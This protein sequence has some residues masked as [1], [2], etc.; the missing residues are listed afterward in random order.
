MLDNNT[1]LPAFSR[2]HRYNHQYCLSLILT[3]EKK[4]HEEFRHSI[5]EKKAQ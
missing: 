1:I 2:Q 5:C 4:V 3:G